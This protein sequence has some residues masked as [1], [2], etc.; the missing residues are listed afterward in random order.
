[1]ALVTLPNIYCNDA[2]IYDYLGTEGVQLR[3]D[4]HNEATGQTV[5]AV[6]DAP[7]GATS[8]AVSPLPSRLYRGTVLTFDGAG[9]P[10]VVEATLT[11]T[12]LQGAIV[13]AVLPLPNQVNGQA[14]AFDSGVNVALNARLLKAAQ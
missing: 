7:L 1:M 5:Q 6:A 2:D 13:L 14:T 10:A 12:A 3:L 8:I 4:D 11:A 9:M